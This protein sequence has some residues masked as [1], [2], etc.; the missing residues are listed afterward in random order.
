MHAWARYAVIAVPLVLGGIGF[1][2][3]PAMRL[4]TSWLAIANSEVV[5]LW[6]MTIAYL[7]VFNRPS[8]RSLHDL[9]VSTAVVRVEAQACPQVPVRR[10][11][12]IALSVVGTVLVCGAFCQAPVRGGARGSIE[13]SAGRYG[14]SGC[15]TNRCFEPASVKCALI[16][17][18]VDNHHRGRWHASIAKRSGR[19]R[20]R[21]CRI[22]RRAD[23]GQPRL[24]Y[25]GDGARRRLGHCYLAAAERGESLGARMGGTAEGARGFVRTQ[26]Q[27]LQ[28]SFM[29][30]PERDAALVVTDACLPR[31]A[32]GDRGVRHQF[33]TSR[34]GGVP[35][36]LAYSRLNWE[37]LS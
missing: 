10:V 15:A 37:G 34:C 22:H 2:D 36:C 29:P 26:P 5:F 32:D 14:R 18:H 33:V 1:V 17:W 27:S 20:D 6:G 7:L 11:H 24:R 25:G 9:A 3:T 13:Y 4:G 30:E 19:P 35:N 12:W 31:L 23:A 16:A 21:A 8:R 28:P